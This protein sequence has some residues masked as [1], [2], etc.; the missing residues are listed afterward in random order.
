MVPN[1]DLVEKAMLDGG[2]IHGMRKVLRR[3]AAFTLSTGTY[4]RTGRNEA[5]VAMFEWI[6]AEE[7]HGRTAK[8]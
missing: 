6:P 4:R 3:T 7:E 1:G 8:G 5:G 2:P